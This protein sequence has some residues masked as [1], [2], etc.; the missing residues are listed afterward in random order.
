MFFLSTHLPHP[1]PPTPNPNESR[2]TEPT[3]TQPTRHQAP[4]RGEHRDQAGGVPGPAAAVRLALL[5][6]HLGGGR[7]WY[8]CFS[9]V[10]VYIHMYLPTSDLCTCACANKP[11][12]A[13]IHY[14]PADEGSAP[15]L[16]S[17]AE[18]AAERGNGNNGGASIFCG[19]VCMCVYALARLIREPVSCSLLLSQA[20]E[21]YPN[22][23]TG[24]MIDGW[25]GRPRV[26]A[27]A[28]SSCSSTRAGSTAT[29]PPT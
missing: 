29:A 28:T 5:R 12:G 23:K 27:P 20:R 3:D 22:H 6:H 17:I 10:D 24:S 1:P 26:R 16:A 18:E 2:L 25:Q 19:C 8:C 9:I 4:D 21:A 13:I 7:Q 14:K 11:T 15:L